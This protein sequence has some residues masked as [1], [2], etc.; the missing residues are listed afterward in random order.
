[1]KEEFFID[2]TSSIWR[3]SVE[4]TENFIKACCSRFNELIKVNG[5]VS[6]YEVYT[7]IGFIDEESERW[8]SEEY[9][10]QLKTTG[11]KKD[12]DGLVCFEIKSC[13]G[14]KWKKDNNGLASFRIEPYSGLK[15]EF[16][17]SPIDN[18]GDN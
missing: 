11:W 9:I 3:N 17:T 4:E 14:L 6:L 10:Q 8:F 13:N 16:D 1:M 18:K 15:L 12:R 2:S 7:I 5:K